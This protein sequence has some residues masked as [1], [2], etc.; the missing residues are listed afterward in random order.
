MLKDIDKNPLGHKVDMS[1]YYDVISIKPEQQEKAE[2]KKSLQDT[3]AKVLC[4]ACNVYI[5]KK[6]VNRHNKG[7]KHRRN[8]ANVAISVE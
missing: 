5:A 7:F 6:N 3:H 1:R 2:E 8:V 4:D